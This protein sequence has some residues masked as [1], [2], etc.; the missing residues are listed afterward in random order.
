MG[1]PKWS[2]RR[3]TQEEV[4]AC[5]SARLPPSVLYFRQMPRPTLSIVLPLYDEEEVVPLL[6]ERLQEFLAKLG[7]DC[8]VIFVNDGS[9]DRTLSLLREIAK[10]DPR[11]RVVGFARNFGHQNAITAGVDYARGAAVVVMDGDLQ[12]P[13]E[14][15]LEMVDRWRSGYDVVYGQRRTRV[16]ESWF[17]QATARWFYRVFKMMIPIEVPLD[18]GDFRLMS[19]QVVIVL[20]QLRE[21]HRFIRG[22]VSWIGFKQTA[23]LFDRPGRAAGETKYPLRKMVRFAI[24]GI[25]SFSIL[26]L[27]FATYLGIVLSLLS[28]LYALW[29]LFA[30][31]VLQHTVQG[32][33]T[34][35]VLVALFASVQLLMTGILGEYIGRI[36]EQVKLRPLYVVGECVNLPEGRDTDEI[37]P[38]DA[39]T[40]LPG[41]APAPPEATT[42]IVGRPQTPGAP[43]Q[44]GDDA[45]FRTLLGVASPANP[46]PVPRLAPLEHVPTAPQLPGVVVEPSSD[47]P[48]PPQAVTRPTQTLVKPPNQPSKPPPPV[49]SKPPPPPGASKPPPPPGASKPPPPPGASSVSKQSVPPP[50]PSSV[51]KQPVPPSVPKAKTEGGR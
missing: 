27:R 17:K 5:D 11:Y 19:R 14:V 21:T 44:D 4:Q 2:C 28:V 35:V 7:L 6:H 51:P 40:L 46:P 9:K 3:P 37:D 34:T 50:V 42:S 16:G 18:A 12:D 32:W 30:H 36:Y 15:V 29:A 43:E 48:P 10:S 45:R 33:T 39:R 24:D 22:I 1:D 41:P 23:V 31:F 26:P 13:P 38:V 47:V 49:P 20:R 25:T 8:E